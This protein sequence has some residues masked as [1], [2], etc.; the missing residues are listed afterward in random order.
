MENVY[1]DSIILAKDSYIEVQTSIIDS[2]GREIN[3]CNDTLS[4]VRTDNTKLQKKVRRN[5]RIAIGGFSLAGIFILLFG[6]K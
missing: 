3:A 2:R 5:K 4:Q 1:K 6:I